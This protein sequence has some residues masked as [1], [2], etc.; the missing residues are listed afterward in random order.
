[1]YKFTQPVVIQF[2]HP[3][4]EDKQ[5]RNGIKPWNTG[6]HKRNFIISAGKFVSS[7]KGHLQESKQI[8]FWGEWEP[9]AKI[10]ETYSK[11]SP[12]PCRSIEPLFPKGGESTRS[13]NSCGR[14]SCN[15]KC[16]GTVYINT[17]PF[18]FGN[19]FKYSNCRQYTKKGKSKTI[20]QYLP[21]GS[22]I[23][24]GSCIKQKKE[25]VFVLDT[26]FVVQKSIKYVPKKHSE[27]HSNLKNDYELFKAA[28]LES[29]KKGK[30]AGK[31]F[32]LYLGYRYS[33][34]NRKNYSF[35]PCDKNGKPFAKV[36]L[37]KKDMPEL[38]MRLR[39]FK[40]LKDSKNDYL[41]PHKVWEKV[42]KV[43]LKRKLSLGVRFKNVRPLPQASTKRRDLDADSK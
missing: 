7:L 24:F 23:L 32:T 6:K 9:E 25:D 4:P 20:L 29:L 27:L 10:W 1:M 14:S 19:R 16:G 33:N 15:S 11:K 21:S 5:E 28:T 38:S 36:A 31:E 8:S 41:D 2:V 17:D 18:V 37:T 42:A 43:V 34:K 13:T 26:V 35:V 22:V 40:V 3:S 12:Y 30:I 39:T